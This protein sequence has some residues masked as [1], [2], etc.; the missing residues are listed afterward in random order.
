MLPPARSRDW[1][2]SSYGGGWAKASPRLT[3]SSAN[4][5]ICQLHV[6]NK[7][8]KAQNSWPLS[9]PGSQL[10]AQHMDMG[11][12]SMLFRLLVVPRFGDIK[13]PCAF[14]K[15]MPKQFDQGT[16]DCLSFSL[17]P[18]VSAE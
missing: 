11:R 6:G 3:S 10:T 1:L 5:A 2:I 7:Q 14:G 4:S 8:T 16:G 12:S 18:G 17:T 15:S 13:Q 9:S